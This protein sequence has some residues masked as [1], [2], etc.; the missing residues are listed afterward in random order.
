[1]NGKEPP[2]GFAKLKETRPDETDWEALAREA[3]RDRRKGKRLPLRYPI[4]VSGIDLAGLSFTERGATV[5]VSQAGCRIVMQ[6][7]LERGDVVAIKVTARP[8][9][10]EPKDKATLFQVIWIS[11][12]ED[13]WMVGMLKLQTDE[14]W[15]VSFPE[16]K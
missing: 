5:D 12:H 11:R 3:M 10:H 14:I 7:K 4:E 15:D 6:K 13:G 1:M 9:H 2:R 16:G 8:D